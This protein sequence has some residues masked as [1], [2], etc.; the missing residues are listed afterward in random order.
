MQKRYLQP[1][2]RGAVLVLVISLLA[3]C[4]LSHM[5]DLP[6][7]A[8]SPLTELPVIAARLTT[9]GATIDTLTRA[10]ELK[11]LLAECVSRLKP[12][13]PDSFGTTGQW[14]HYN[15]LYFPYV[16][17]LRPY[18]QKYSVTPATSQIAALNVAARLVIVGH[19]SSLLRQ[20]P[21]LKQV[22]TH[23]HPSR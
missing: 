9:R 16:V 18:S 6:R 23:P 3:G 14:R 19:T 12:D 10:A 22:H 21:E 11:T 17:G 7:L 4:A 5:G 2:T 13:S 15:A 20:H 8:A 1:I